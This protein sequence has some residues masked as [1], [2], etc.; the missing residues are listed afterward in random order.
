MANL[1]LVT[2]P[3]G[4]SGDLTFRARECLSR[5]H[6][7]YCEDTRVFRDL[8]QR[9]EIDC[10]GKK[11]YSFHEHSGQKQLQNL[12]ELAWVEDVVFVSD[13]GSPVISDPAYPLIVA[14]INDEKVKLKS[15]G[16][17]S[18][19]IVA[20][21]LA[22]LPSTP[23]HFHGFLARDNGKRQQCADLVGQ[24]Y[25]THVFFEGKSRVMTTLA[26]MTS[27]Y[28][29]LKFAV[30]RELTKEFESI[31][32]FYGRE[33]TQQKDS[34]D[35]R[36]EFVILVHNHVKANLSFDDKELIALA[37]EIL[38]SGARPKVLSKLLSRVLNKST[39][40]IYDKLKSTR[41]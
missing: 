20:L 22:G 36:G 32:R 25:G 29:D 11:I 33:Y 37:E 6:H 13:A 14:A 18:S 41:Q 19:V 5:S 16:G 9:V 2:L 17:V 39:K 4:N 8:C 38:E 21:E 40:D 7:I 26:L 1:Y 35:M 3:I 28:P 23:F 24:Q 31:Y 10:C 27:M 12:L 15:L 34:I 30:A